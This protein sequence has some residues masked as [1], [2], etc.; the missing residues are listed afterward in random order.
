MNSSSYKKELALVKGKL[1]STLHR[2]SKEMLEGKYVD[3]GHFQR[4]FEEQESVDHQIFID[5]LMIVSGKE[6]RG[7]RLQ[8]RC[9]VVFEDLM[10]KQSFSGGFMIDHGWGSQSAELIVQ[11]F[12][13]DVVLDDEEN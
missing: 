3:A 5:R 11:D 4:Y 8:L 9:D 10:I 13:L 2:V 6:M 7:V 12:F 1:M